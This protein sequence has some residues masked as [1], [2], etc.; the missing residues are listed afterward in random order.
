MNV[1]HEND[2]DKV[3]AFHRWD[4]GGPRDDVVVVL[5]FANRAYDVYRVGLPRGGWWRVRFNS[6]SRHYS[7]V[8][9]DHDSFDCQ[10]RPG[11][12]DGLPFSGEIG[13]G[14]YSAVILSQDD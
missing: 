13:L 1:H 9:T 5:N 11:G 2:G 12:A 7:A 14:P 10:A 6:D 8:F 4:R 3:I